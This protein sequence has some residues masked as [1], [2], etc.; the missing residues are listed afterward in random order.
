MHS[1]SGQPS[2]AGVPPEVAHT[3][4]LDFNDIEGVA[5]AFEREGKDIAAVIVEPVA[6]NMN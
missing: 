3:L 4:V 5:R 1:R 6:G 2:S